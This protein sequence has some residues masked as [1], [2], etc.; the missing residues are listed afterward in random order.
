MVQLRASTLIVA[1]NHT[2]F[3]PWGALQQH[4]HKMQLLSLGAAAAEPRGQQAAGFP[5]TAPCIQAGAF[6]HA[7]PS[8]IHFLATPAHGTSLSM[9]PCPLCTSASVSST[10][11]EL[12]T[13]MRC[14]TPWS[15]PQAGHPQPDSTQQVLAVP[16]PEGPGRQV[17]HS[18]VSVLG[19][20]NQDHLVLH[21]Q[22][23]QVPRH[24]PH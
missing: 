3:M 11:H 6:P 8:W 1:G 18:W 21:N 12:S 2:P 14:Q 17:P 22:P 7:S 24:S 20:P 16:W 13:C 19:R 23:R 9:P 10:G 5:C 4:Q 15:P